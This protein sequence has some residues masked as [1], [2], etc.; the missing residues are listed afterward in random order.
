MMDGLKRIFLGQNKL[1]LYKMMI[2]EKIF[3]LNLLN[4]KKNNYVVTSIHAL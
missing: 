3:N 2:K 1:E 4:I